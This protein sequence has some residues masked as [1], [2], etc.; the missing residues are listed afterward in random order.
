MSRLR[1]GIFMAPFHPAG[2][3]PTIALHRDLRLVEHLDELGFD[4]A[5]IGEHHSAGSGDHRLAGDLHRGGGGAHQAHQARHRR[6]VAELPQ[7]AVGGRAD[8]AARPP[9]PRPVHARPRPGL[10]AHRRGDDRAQPDRDPRA[11]RRRTRHHHAAAARRAGDRA[12]HDPEPRRRPAAPAPYTDPLFDV[13]VAAVASPTGPR[14]AGRYGV[15]LLSI[16]AT[17]TARVRRA[18]PPLGRRGG[19]GGARSAAD[20][21]TGR[22]GGWSA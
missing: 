3:N 13:A 20:A 15:G 19:A 5:W 18:R 14:L 10:A 1:F 11:A 8:R 21:S 22:S 6:D 4:E 2:E 12:D 9:D 17:L 16:G 7:P